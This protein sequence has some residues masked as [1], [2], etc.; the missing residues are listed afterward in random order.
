M[1]QRKLEQCGKFADRLA[2][3]VVIEFACGL[4]LIGAYTV[5]GGLWRVLTGLLF[6]LTFVVGMVA[7]A[8]MER[9]RAAQQKGDSDA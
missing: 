2:V 1:E 8:V 3:A 5:V 6:I 7:L 9:R 4:Y